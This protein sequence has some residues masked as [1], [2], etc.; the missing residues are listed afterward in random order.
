MSVAQTTLTNV[1]LVSI[2]DGCNPL[3]GPDLKKAKTLRFSVFSSLWEKRE[4]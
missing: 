4:G 1:G 2:Q 3:Y